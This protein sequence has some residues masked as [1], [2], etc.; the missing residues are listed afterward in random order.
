M[1]NP[2]SVIRSGDSDV[3]PGMTLYSKLGRLG[4]F[5]LVEDSISDMGQFFGGIAVRNGSYHHVLRERSPLRAESHQIL[6][7]V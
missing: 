4:L 2:A 5:N 1:V 7:A 3:L 6:R